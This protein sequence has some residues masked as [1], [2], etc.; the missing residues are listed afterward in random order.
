[1]AYVDGFVLPVPKKNLDAY[2]RMARKAGKVWMEHG[3]LDFKECA[4]DDLNIPGMLSFPKAMKLK[5]GETVLFSWITY[6]SRAHR[7]K[8]NKKVMADPRLSEGPNAMPF[9]PKRM[10]YGG[11]KTLVDLNPTRTK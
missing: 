3:A 6:K 4:G 9:D 7:D 1:M 8:V 2:K 10:M 5:P 11:F